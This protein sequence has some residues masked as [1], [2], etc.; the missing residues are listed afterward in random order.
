[1][2]IV[3]ESHSV[4]VESSGEGV[5]LSYG[6]VGRQEKQGGWRLVGVAWRQKER[7]GWR[8]VGM[9]WRRGWLRYMAADRRHG[10]KAGEAGEAWLEGCCL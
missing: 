8:L 5:L 1:V 2:V 7:G 4:G 6:A 3:H 9:A 10:W